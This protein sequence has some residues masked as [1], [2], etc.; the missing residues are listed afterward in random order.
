MS[1]QSNMNNSLNNSEKE[2]VNNSKVNVNSNI[3]T[4]HSIKTLQPVG[5]N[6]QSG[7]GNIVSPLYKKPG[8]TL[9]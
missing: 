5:K 6:Q 7:A 8:K 2:G 3:S 9:T 4:K 1:E